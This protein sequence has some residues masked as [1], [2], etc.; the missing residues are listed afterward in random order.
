MLA[1]LP[2]IGRPCRWGSLLALKLQY[3]VDVLS[4]RLGASLF[5]DMILIAAQKFLI[6]AIDLTLADFDMIMLITSMTLMRFGWDTLLP[7]LEIPENFRTLAVTS[8]GGLIVYSRGCVV[9]CASS[10]SLTDMLST[11]N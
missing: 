3:A 2:E 6:V 8:C 11:S 7:M 1:T 5:R 10:L 9:F 4:T